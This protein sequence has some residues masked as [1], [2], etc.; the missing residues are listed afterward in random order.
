MN[1]KKTSLFVGVI[2]FTTIAISHEHLSKGKGGK[3][4]A[5][6]HCTHFPQ[7]CKENTAHDKHNHKMSLPKDWEL[8][9][10]PGDSIFGAIS[11]VN[12]IIEANSDNWENID[13]D[14][15][16]EHLRDMNTLMNF[17]EVNKKELDDGLI[18]E[19]LGGE[20]ASRAV[21]NMIPTHAEFLKPLRPLWDIN[22]KKI[23]GGFEVKI[24][25]KNTQEAS[26]IKALG[27]SGFM[28]QDDH[29]SS[30]HLGIALG[31]N[32]H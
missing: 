26:K 23:K 8:P 29:H 20:N 16:W 10:E 4:D 12:K 22:Y 32:V 15:L 7:D 19:I 17:S 14:S 9:L 3:H 28:V 6:L 2:L 21:N 31:E 27:F 11:E 1:F 30:H 24:T 25:S 13:L 18:M 5:N